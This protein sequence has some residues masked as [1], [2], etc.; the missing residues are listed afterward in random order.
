MLNW[1]KN[2][3]IKKKPHE[4]QN[5]QI[6]IT[7]HGFGRRLHKEMDNLVLWGETDGYEVI[8]FDLY[9]MYNPEDND[10]RK[11]IQRAE[12][13]LEKYDTPDNDIYL[14]GFSMGG[15][16]ASY[17]AT[18]YSIKR[19]ILIAPAFSYLNVENITS[20][21]TKGATNLLSSPDQDKNKITLPKGFYS[22]F[23]ELVKHLKKYIS[24]VNCPVLLFHGNDDEVISLRSSVQAFEKIPHNRKRLLIL[25]K[26]KHR[27]LQDPNVNWEVYQ[28]IVLFINKKILPDNEIPQATITEYLRKEEQKYESTIMRIILGNKA[29]LI[30]KNIFKNQRFL[31]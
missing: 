11:W 1:I 4:T 7:I 29:Y 18:K 25:H 13:V 12:A 15:V 2:K 31:F 30:F 9:D 24:E 21:I 8:T 22:A 27:L 6:I 20:F 10:W 23:Q 17:L 16:I 14:L 28:N 19:L 3:L 5:K 26:G